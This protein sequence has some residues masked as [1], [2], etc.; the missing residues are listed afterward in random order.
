MINNRFKLVLFLSA[1][2]LF[3]S[4]CNDDSDDFFHAGGGAGGGDVENTSTLFYVSST[5]SDTTGDGSAQSPWKTISKAQEAVR[6]IIPGASEDLTIVLKDGVYPLDS[7]LTFTAQD[8]G[9]DAVNVIYKSENIGKAVISGGVEVTGWTDT[10]ND[11]IWEADVP[12]GAKS[13]QLYVDGELAVRAR[14]KDGNGWRREG[15]SGSYFSPPYASTLSNIENVELVV[16]FLWKQ[17]RGKLQS[18]SNGVAQMNSEYWE[19]AKIGPY[20]ILDNTAGHVSWVENALEL[21]DE[22]NEWYLDGEK[23]KL[24]YKPVADKPLASSTVTLPVLEKLIDGDGVK[25]ITFD[26]IRFEYATWNKPSENTGYVS[27]QSGSILTDPHYLTIE[28]AFEGLYD[29]PGSIHFINSSNISLTNNIF[30]NLGATAVNFGSGSKNNIIF[31]NTFDNISASAITLGDMQ[32]HHT[33]D[34]RITEN[35]LIDNNIIT[36]TGL[37]YLDT[38]AVKFT[39]TRKTVIANNTIESVPYTGISMG[40]GWTRYDVEPISFPN[41]HG[42]KGYNSPTIV[43]GNILFRNKISNFAK[44]LGDTGGIYNLGASPKSR[45]IENLIFDGNSPGEGTH[46][47][48]GIYLD[49]GSRGIQVDD[50]GIYNV[51]SHG[52][53]YNNGGFGS[54]IEYNTLGTNTLFDNH[55]G[56]AADMPEQLAVVTGNDPSIRSPRSIA[57]IESLLPP[58]LTDVPGAE[59]SAFGMLVGYSAT[60]NSNSGDAT[61]MIDGNV[62]TFWQAEPNVDS[63]EI[64]IDTVNAEN[65]FNG[66]VVSFG[67]MIDGKEVYHRDGRTYTIAVSVDGDT[68]STVV[69]QTARPTQKQSIIPSYIP[70]TKARYIKL[71]VTRESGEKLSILRFKA[72]GD[73]GLPVPEGMNIALQGTAT[74]SSTYGDNVASMANDGNT[75]GNWFNNSVSHT[76]DDSQ[77]FWT[78]DLG[79][80]HPINAIRIFNRTDCC[81]ERLS[82]FYVF[83]SD[84]PFSGTTV[85]ETKS[86]T[87]VTFIHHPSAVGKIKHFDIDGSARY[88][89]IQLNSKDESLA[90]AE[91]E[92]YST[93]SDL[94]N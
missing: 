54:G 23:G 17:Y 62:Q 34:D 59:M 40:W 56:T 41:D 36:D 21:L 57:D 79:A 26:G 46:F 24:Y 58:V 14:S 27:I 37:D 91:V 10:N 63:A 7:T 66:F 18:V 16:Q 9:S 25:N 74:Q 8:S 30:S 2:T 55:A 88:I 48:N 11:G 80:I 29:L 28:D 70:M 73:K 12:V 84:Q 71:N 49:N 43:E 85:D 65:M 50:N 86:Q 72:Y 93:N 87:G 5:G 76:S 22:E 67:E 3:L 75:D 20:G 6:T 31:A 94:Q 4:A 53:F 32:D 47:V 77:P 60:T 81:G 69:D 92:V 35:N 61:N 64:I 42:N 83:Y 39:Y 52:Y 51:A 45:I 19:L 15:D 44:G 33:S 82:D 68:W 90:L 78:L 1:S 38:S 89:R 13:R